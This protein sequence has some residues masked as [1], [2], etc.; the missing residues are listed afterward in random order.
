M[1]VPKDKAPPMTRQNVY[2]M[3]FRIQ[4]TGIFS[5]AAEFSLIGETIT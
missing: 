3:G 2:Q 1:E 4:K 5:T